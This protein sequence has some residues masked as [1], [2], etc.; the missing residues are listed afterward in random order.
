MEE[1]EEEKGEYEGLKMGFVMKIEELLDLNGW[2]DKVKALLQ[3]ISYVL[4][5]LLSSLLF[6]CCTLSVFY[7]SNKKA[8]TEV[9]FWT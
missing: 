4:F 2:R 7:C 1:Q 9:L 6:Q 3:A 8:D 5:S